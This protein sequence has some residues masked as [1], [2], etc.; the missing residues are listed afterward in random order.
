MSMTKSLS[1][2]E[3][4]PLREAWE[5]K[6]TISHRGWLTQRLEMMGQII[7]LYRD[8]AFST[9]RTTVTALALGLV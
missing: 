5:T 8:K 4:V 7:A 2:L 9:P 3:R 6:P 1:Q